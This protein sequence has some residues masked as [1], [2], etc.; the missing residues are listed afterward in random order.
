MKAGS[1]HDTD[2]VPYTAEDF[3]FTS[4]HGALYAIEMEWPTNGEAIIHALS[5]S[6]AGTRSVSAV[7]LLG[8]GA[9]LTFTQKTDGLHIQV[10]AEAP[11]KYS[12]VYRIN[13]QEAAQ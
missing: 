1:F 3:R 2:T 6:I 10:P 8:S 4:K 11:G 12:Y 5:S 9:K 7:T 13:F